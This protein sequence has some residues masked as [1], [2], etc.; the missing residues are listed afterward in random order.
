ML[1]HV[2]LEFISVNYSSQRTLIYKFKSA[3]IVM[4]IFGCDVAV[5]NYVHC[6][7]RFLYNMPT[8]NVFNE[9]KLMYSTYCYLY[10]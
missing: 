6:G 4:I 10:K 2:R 1:F 9:E 5:S 8:T 3:F 7:V